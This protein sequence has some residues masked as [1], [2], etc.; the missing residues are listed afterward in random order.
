MSPSA[1]MLTSG[2]RPPRY[3][4]MPAPYAIWPIRLVASFILRPRIEAAA[5][6]GLGEAAVVGC[7]GVVKDAQDA[8]GIEMQHGRAVER[9]ARDDIG[10][11]VRHA[12]TVRA[13]VVLGLEIGRAALHRMHGAAGTGRWCW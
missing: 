1:L 9:R 2:A 5:A 7:Q 6:A 8:T 3:L 11:Q 10:H 13:D 12:E 4:P